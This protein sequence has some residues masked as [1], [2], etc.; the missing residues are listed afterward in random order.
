[1]KKN[2]FAFIATFLFVSASAQLENTRWKARLKIN[3][4]LLI[5]IF[6]FKKDTLSIYA[7]ADSTLIERM[8]YTNN[9]S[10]F[11]LL[12]IEGQSDCDNANTG[13]YGFTLTGDSLFLKLIKDNCYDRFSVIQNTRMVKWK[14][15]P[16]II[17][18]EAILKQYTGVYGL[19]DAHPI[20]ISLE[21]G[22][23]Y[24]E[25]PNNKLPKSPF[26]AVTESKFFLRVAGVEMDFVKDAKGNIV[27]LISHEEKDYE[28]KKIK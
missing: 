21:K 7:V 13:E 18:D 26:T 5:T 10:S 24:A 22:V 9:D 23:L 19:D 16:G 27:K 17:V 28:L 20:T 3:E 11:T 1:M 6:D 25:G 15:Y 2:S 12:K 8:I 4:G 14:N